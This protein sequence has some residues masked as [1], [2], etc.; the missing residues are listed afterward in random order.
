MSVRWLEGAWDMP[1]KFFG[2]LCETLEDISGLL[3]RLRKVLA[4]AVGIAFG[5]LACFLTQFVP[6]L[7]HMCM[8]NGVS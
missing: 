1:G 6:P 4:R 3:E 2:D 8:Q 5:C 7:L